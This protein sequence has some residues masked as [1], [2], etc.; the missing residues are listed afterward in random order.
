MRVTRDGI[1]YELTDKGAR[2]ADADKRTV[3]AMIPETCDNLPVT[4]VEK[5]AFL[6]CKSLKSVILPAGI[7]VIG[8]WAFA[9]CDALTDFEMGNEGCTFGK[10]V[11]D[12]DLSLQR[13]GSAGS[14]ETYRHLMARAVT[15]MKA[16]YMLDRTSGKESDWYR[17]WDSKLEDIMRLAD[18]D[19]Y[20]LYSLC[21][22]EDLHLDY[23]EYLE[24]T[25]RHK[26]SLA[27]LRLLWDDHLDDAFR[28]ELTG[29]I[30]DHG[31]LCSSEAAWT[32]VIKEH[33]SD[34]EYYELMIRT[35]CI[36]RNNLE[37]AL[38]S[39]G[40]RHAEAK[41]FLINS[42]NKEDSTGGFFDSLLL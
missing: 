28:E 19:G 35:G 37:A 17:M 2:V 30:R 32:H 23:D 8:D 39:L 33:G 15:D 22:E 12:Q 31:P 26:S 34:I 1:C 11:F 7:S 10:G 9:R 27:M 25:R 6:G 24:Y 14:S 3:R 41:A 42:F 40:D 38:K 16:E 21:G 29:Y 36:D 13:L 5:K 4:S 20:H 18:D